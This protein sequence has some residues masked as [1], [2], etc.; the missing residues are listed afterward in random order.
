MCF[1][2]SINTNTYLIKVDISHKII[3]KNRIVIKKIEI[4]FF[5][6]HLLNIRILYPILPTYYKN[7]KTY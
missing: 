7:D 3:C 6:L 1:I 5:I 2:K 4:C